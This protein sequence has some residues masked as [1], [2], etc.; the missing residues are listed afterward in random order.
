MVPAAQRSIFRPRPTMAVRQSSACSGWTGN[1]NGFCHRLAD[2]CQRPSGWRFLYLWGHG[3]EQRWLY[4]RLIR[5]VGRHN[6]T[7]CQHCSAFPVLAGLRCAQ[8]SLSNGELCCG[9]AKVTSV[10]W[11]AYLRASPDKNAPNGAPIA[12]LHLPVAG[13]CRMCLFS[14]RV[15]LPFKRS[16][17]VVGTRN[18]LAKSSAGSGREIR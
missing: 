18:C 1:A 9:H 7:S 2:H 3:D 12:T 14:S 10:S 6:D 13:G 4:H 11:I 5:V 8:W 15:R 16:I 17:Y